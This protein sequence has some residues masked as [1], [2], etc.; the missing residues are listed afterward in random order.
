MLVRVIM[1]IV[2]VM[3]KILAHV[4]LPD[5]RDRKARTANPLH[6]W[7]PKDN[8]VRLERRFPCHRCPHNRAECVRVDRKASMV[9]QVPADRQDRK[10][11]PVRPE[12]SVA[13]AISDRVAPLDRLE[14]RAA[15]A[16]PV[17]K[18]HRVVMLNVAIKVQPDLQAKQEMLAVLVVMVKK[19]P[20][21][22]R[23]LQADLVQLVPLVQQDNQA[24]TVHQDR[25][26]N[27]DQKAKMLN[28]V[29]VRV[30]RRNMPRTKVLCLN[31]ILSDFILLNLKLF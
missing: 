11:N 14:M 31:A 30:I 25:K 18:V 5:L 20:T 17:P 1:V 13:M 15:M 8:Q 23:V 3:T 12:K 24:Q 21:V 9:R 28:I 6:Q 19:E 4:V 29:L 10:D 7:V 16:K 2:T 26:G 22:V 27:Q